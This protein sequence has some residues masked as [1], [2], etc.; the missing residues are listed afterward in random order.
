MDL[1]PQGA[2]GAPRGPKGPQGGPRGPKGPKGAQG[3]PRR[4][5]L[6]P[7]SDISDDHIRGQYEG[8]ILGTYFP[9][10]GPR[11]LWGRLHWSH[12]PFIR[13]VQ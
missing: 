1:G 7:I 5:P 12:N 11:A 6:A 8:E 4:I 13:L 2:H 3:P 9:F 10:V